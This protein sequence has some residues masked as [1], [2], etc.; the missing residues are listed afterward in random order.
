MNKSAVWYTFLFD[1]ESYK[2]LEAGDERSSRTSTIGKFVFDDSE[3]KDS[4]LGDQRC[5][6]YE[7]MQN[8]SAYELCNSSTTSKSD[9]KIIV[10]GFYGKAAGLLKLASAGTYL[11]IYL[12]TR[13]LV[14]LAILVK[15][16]VIKQLLKQRE[17]L[18]LFQHL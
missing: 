16:S 6:S 12:E 13:L 8:N 2:S 5:N 3:S 17:K 14:I 10:N 15:Q 18:N 9:E 11:L 7:C 1:S 4:Q